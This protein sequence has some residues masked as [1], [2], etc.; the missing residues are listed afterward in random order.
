MCAARPCEPFEAICDLA[1]GNSTGG[2]DTDTSGDTDTDTDG[3]CVF[4]VDEA[5]SAA[6]ST[7]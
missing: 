2:G 7:S 6:R 1:P 4:I 3:D 5:S